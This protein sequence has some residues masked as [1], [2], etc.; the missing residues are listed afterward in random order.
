[1]VADGTSASAS[2]GIYLYT[3]PPGGLHQAGSGDLKLLGT[4]HALVRA[5]QIM[6]EIAA[7]AGAPRRP[8]ATRQPVITAHHPDARPI[9]SLEV[10]Q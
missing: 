7:L 8:L 6:F 1:M 4:V 2:T 5:E 3:A 9:S 10:L